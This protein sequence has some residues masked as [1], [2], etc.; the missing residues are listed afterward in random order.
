MLNDN[1]NTSTGTNPSP[2][3]SPEK[4]IF[5]YWFYATIV[6]ECKRAVHEDRDGSGSHLIECF[7]TNSPGSRKLTGKVLLLNPK[8]FFLKRRFVHHFFF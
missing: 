2:V 6:P 7:Y 4:T 8:F 3:S 5:L 1:L